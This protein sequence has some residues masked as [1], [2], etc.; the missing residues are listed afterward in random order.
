LHDAFSLNWC[1]KLLC[2]SYPY[3]DRKISSELL[4]FFFQGF[5]YFFL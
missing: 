3:K 2:I 1:I 4:N 5:H